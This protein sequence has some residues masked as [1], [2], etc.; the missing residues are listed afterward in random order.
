M[1]GALIG[2]GIVL[3]VMVALH[4]LLDT[5]KHF[6]F[7]LLLIVFVMTTSLLVVPKM[8]IDDYTICENLVA[9]STTV[10]ATTS[11]EYALECSPHPSST[12]IT[13]YKLS[14]TVFYLFIGY[15]IVFLAIWSFF[16]LRDSV[17]GGK[18]G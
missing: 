16:K 6:I 12:D 9:N 7:Q 11:Y 8:V 2:V 15:L 18:R 3:L 13:F 14:T 10:G 4:N 5:D 1:I 17:S